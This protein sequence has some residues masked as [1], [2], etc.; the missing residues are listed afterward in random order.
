MPYYNQ[1]FIG[2]LEPYVNISKPCI[3]IMI[4]YTLSFLTRLLFPL[5]RTCI[6]TQFTRKRSISSVYGASCSNS[7]T[8]TQSSD[9]NATVCKYLFPNCFAWLYCAGIWLIYWLLMFFHI[10]V[11]AL[12]CKVMDMAMDMHHD[13]IMLWTVAEGTII[14]CLLCNVCGLHLDRRRTSKSSPAVATILENELQVDSF[15]L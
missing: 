12:W 9:A 15:P 11:I 4:P 5:L 3:F 1:K 10:E 7:W 2:C 13:H 8:T 6:W 14:W